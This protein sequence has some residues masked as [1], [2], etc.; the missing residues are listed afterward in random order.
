[1]TDRNLQKLIRERIWDKISEYTQEMDREDEADFLEDLGK[2]I[3]DRA[4]E[5]YVILREDYER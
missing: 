1:M 3:S 5:L 4:K 2:N